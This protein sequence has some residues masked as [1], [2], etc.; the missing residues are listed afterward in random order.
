MAKKKNVNKV[1]K[2]EDTDYFR[3]AMDCYNGTTLCCEFVYNACKRFL[4]DLDNP[5]FEF[6]TDKVEECFRFFSCLKHF[7]G[8]SAGK[9]FLLERW[10]KFILANL[11]GFY[12]KDT[13]TRRF[14]QAYIEVPRKNG[15]TAL[16]SALAMRMLLDEKG[17]EVILAAPSFKQAQIAFEFC[18]KFGRDLDPN[19]K[20]FKTYRDNI[21]L[22]ETDSKLFCVASDANRLDGYNPS[23]AI[24]DEFHQHPDSK[25]LNA[26]IQGMNNRPSAMACIITTAGVDTSSPCY[27]MHQECIEILKGL[28]KD[29]SF[30][31]IIYSLDIDK[32]NWENP[33]CWVK[34]IPNLGVTVYEHALKDLVERSLNNPSEES[35]TKTK[36][37]N[38]W[39]NT[40]SVWIPDK[41]V[42]DCSKD[43]DFNDFK[44]CETYMG[45]DL[46]SVSDLTAVSFL[47]V[48]GD[49][50]FIKSEYYLPEETIKISPNR[51]KYKIW[52]RQGKLKL[53]QGNVTDYDIILKDILDKMKL[54]RVQKVAY[55]Q[56][57]STQFAIT[58]TAQ[59]V[60]LEPF[61][62]SLFNF[63]RPTKEF[64][65]RILSGQIIID[66]NEINRWCI[67]NATL[68]YDLNNNCKPVKGNNSSKAMKDNKIDGVI[69]MIQALG[70]FLQTPRFTG[71]IFTL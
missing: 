29:D 62:Q 58:A 28:K 31:T 46:A 52:V 7:K 1:I 13:G 68:K 44:G 35:H 11:L 6:R 50:L 23:F 16:I 53:T 42:L 4:N 71:S 67:R 61:S 34:A 66:N 56:Y 24:V 12:R 33:E 60:P 48:K 10:Q 36:N 32:D 37:F 69:A 19:G 70:I 30:F 41:Y 26:L 20:S 40:S 3:Y 51:E 55:D 43:I 22:P 25:V 59:G 63:N 8:A 21:K 5:K 17:A 65:R 49:N 39:L 64:E 54:L 45:I 27:S 18:Q 38:I 47:M 2:V 14:R 15:K 9:P 57:N